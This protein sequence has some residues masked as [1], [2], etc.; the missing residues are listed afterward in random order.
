MVVVSMFVCI[1]YDDGGI[2]FGEKGGRGLTMPGSLDVALYPLFDGFDVF[3]GV[4]QIVTH[5]V[6]F[7]A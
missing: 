7:A 3:G 5:L 2:Q 1:V 6:D 4:L